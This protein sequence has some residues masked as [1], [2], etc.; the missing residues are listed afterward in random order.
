[1]K[2]LYEEELGS[3]PAAELVWRLEDAL[4]AA[5]TEKKAEERS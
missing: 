2:V 4:D 3:I 1:M 5:K